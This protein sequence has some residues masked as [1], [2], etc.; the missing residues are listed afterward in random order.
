M[1]KGKRKEQGSPMKWQ[2]NEGVRSLYRYETRK[3]RNETG[4]GQER[5][6]KKQ[7]L[8]FRIIIAM[9]DNSIQFSGK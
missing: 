3:Y 5:K 4:K 9:T 8:I 1:K 7:I 6:G 2:N